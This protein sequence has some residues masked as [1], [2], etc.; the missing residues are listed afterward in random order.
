MTRR[1]AL[2]TLTVTLAVSLVVLLGGTFTTTANQR[3][4]P[5]VTGGS[6]RSTAT[7]ADGR[8]RAVRTGLAAHHVH[9]PGTHVT[10]TGAAF[11]RRVAAADRGTDVAVVRSAPAHAAVR[12]SPVAVRFAVA[13]DSV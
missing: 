8:R 7:G 11:I 4:S 3:S 2:A 12:P 13:Y 10:D 6:G 9:S 5:A 1:L